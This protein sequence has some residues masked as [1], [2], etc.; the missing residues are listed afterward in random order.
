VS[1]DN[2]SGVCV[3]GKVRYADEQD[4]AVALE[5]VRAARAE[6]P[7]G[8][9][10]ERVFYPCEHC[11]GW[12][13]SSRPPKLALADPPPRADGETWQEY[14]HRLERR[15]KEQRDQL[16][17]INQLRADAGNRH[18]RKRIALLQASL[19]RMTERWEKERAARIGLVNAMAEMRGSE[20]VAA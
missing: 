13:L 19:G 7:D 20:D 9:P 14:A 3:T 18:E 1:S 11:D 4:A 15:I 12:H 5:R 6:R 8:H 2:R 10:P 17:Q 16:E